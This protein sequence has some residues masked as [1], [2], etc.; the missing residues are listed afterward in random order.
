MITIYGRV[1]SRTPRV[2]WAAEEMGLAYKHVSVDH[3]AGD[4]SSPE[5]L[6]I[7]PNGKIPALVD[8]DTKLFESMA[9]NFYLAAKYA[10]DLLPESETDRA[11]ALQWSFWGMSEIESKIITLFIE[12]V[13]KSPAERSQSTID[14]GRAQLDRMLAVLEEHLRD[15]YY[16]LGA[17][18][19]IADLNLASIMALYKFIGPPLADL[20]ESFPKA[21]AWLNDQCLSRPAFQKVMAMESPPAD[22]PHLR[23]AS[24]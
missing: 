23:S 10:T 9:I 19:T 4:T 2:L 15:R 11:L 17:R 14:E 24:T 7:N 21:N 8:G 18:F 5:F 12:L 3:K 16:L 1:Y 13:R 22:L 20:L 6:A